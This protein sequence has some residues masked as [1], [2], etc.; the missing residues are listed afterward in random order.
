MEADPERDGPYE[1]IEYL[2]SSGSQAFAFG[3]RNS[4][5][6]GYPRPS[7]WRSTNA[8]GAWQ[9]II[10]AREFFGGPNV[11]AFGGTSSGPHGEFVA[12]TWTNPNGRTVL[13]VWRS[14]DGST[15][16]QDASDPTF[17]GL[18]GEIPFAS[19][20]ADNS[21]GVLLSAAVEIPT[22][23][24]PTGRR[25]AIWFSSDGR[26]WNRLFAGKLAKQWPQSVFGAVVA[27]PTGWSIA[28]ESGAAGVPTVWT[29]GESGASI[30]GTT[31]PGVGSGA[32]LTAI[33]AGP[34]RVVA[35]GVARGRPVMWARVGSGGASN[36]APVVPPPATDVQSVA[37]S[38]GD[39]GTIV[40]LIGRD[41]TSVW[42]TAWH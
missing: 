5:T 36:W 1:T 7:V 14:T 35:A 23:A 18:A 12:G 9:E 32:T 11:I 17:E 4:P 33:S 13:S 26:H 19:G 3:W 8:V 42:T 30:Q 38:T 16:A 39:Q 34:T 41:E 15:W 6:E 20:I 27:T 40:L 21:S 29:V 31:L 37:L 24:D 25:G 10:E 2:A 28:G 22:H